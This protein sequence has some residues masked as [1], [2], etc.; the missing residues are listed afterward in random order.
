[1]G[2]PES[3]RTGQGGFSKISRGVGGKEDCCAL[4]CDFGWWGKMGYDESGVGGGVFQEKRLR[5]DIDIR[6][7][8]DGHLRRGQ[9]RRRRMNGGGEGRR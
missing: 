1:M 7:R 4:T 8:C 5:I 3:S 6:G 2:A 9:E